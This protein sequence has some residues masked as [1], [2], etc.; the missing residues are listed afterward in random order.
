MDTR[1]G[2]SRVR[3]TWC[4]RATERALRMNPAHTRTPAF[5]PPEPWECPF[6]LLQL[7]GLLMCCSSPAV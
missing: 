2:R 7:P 5:Q 1:V 4:V 6:L 3:P